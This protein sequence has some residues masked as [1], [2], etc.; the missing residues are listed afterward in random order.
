MSLLDFFD[1]TS[2]SVLMPIAAIGT[3]IFVGYVIKPRTLIEEVEVNGKFKM[4][5]FYSVM[6]KYIAPVCLVA[7]LIFAVMEALGMI[8]V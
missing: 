2:N 3:C 7:I 8:T 6:V 5:K 1:F 4:K